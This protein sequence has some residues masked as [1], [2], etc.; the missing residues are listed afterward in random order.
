MAATGPA[1][2]VSAEAPG[3]GNPAGTGRAEPAAAVAAVIRAAVRAPWTARAR[4]ELLFCLAGLPFGMVNPVVVFFVVVDLLWA[5]TPGRPPNPSWPDVAAAIVVTGLLLA[6]LVATGTARELGSLQRLL[7]ARLLGAR[8]AAPAPVRRS[9]GR[10]GRLGPGLRD[11][12][13]WRAV[14][15][16]AVKLPVALLGLYAVFFWAAGLVNL[17]YPFWWGRSATIRRGC[18]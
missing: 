2:P 16:L 10:L 15:Y 17:S 6:L 13:G 7:A 12:A 18:A 1:S 3:R 11:G 9:S 14:A 5:V 4:R 8:T